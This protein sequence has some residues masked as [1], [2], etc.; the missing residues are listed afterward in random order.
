MKVA[1]VVLGGLSALLLLMGACLY[2]IGEHPTIVTVSPGPSFTMR[3]SGELASFTVYAPRRG[4]RIAFP[5]KGDSDI[6]WQIVATNGYFKG[7]RVSG[8]TIRYGEIPPG[9]SQLVPSQNQAA[10]P[11]AGKMIYSFFAETTN[12]PGA[13]AY[14]YMDG[15]QPTLSFVPDLCITLKDGRYVR[16][17]C[18]FG[19]DRTYSEP[20]NLDEVVRKYR[21]KDSSKFDD[22]IEDEFNKSCE[23]DQSK[24]K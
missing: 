7:A 5:H 13:T 4:N 12:A 21:Q 23:P 16:V 9:Y 14:F 20:A 1:T 15:A 2:V 17:K 6:A 19:G 11:P 3:G 18:G 8:L 24:A 10:I 22:L